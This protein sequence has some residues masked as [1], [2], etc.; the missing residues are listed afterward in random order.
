MRQC[1][2]GQK[3]LNHFLAPY[4]YS[5][6]WI[7]DLNFKVSILQI[8]DKNIRKY[9]QDFGIHFLKTLKENTVKIDVDTLNYNKS[10]K[11]ASKYT[12]KIVKGWS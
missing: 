6:Q 2:C 3:K 8:I 10:R 7:K 1:I 11:S 12:I 9:L 5:F 4:N